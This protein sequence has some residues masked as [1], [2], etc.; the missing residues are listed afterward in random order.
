MNVSQV[1]TVKLL[2]VSDDPLLRQQISA[3]LSGSRQPA[4]EITLSTPAVFT[5]AE[6]ILD[7]FE[8]CL[9][10]TS[11]MRTPHSALIDQFLDRT[12]ALPVVMI[13]AESDLDSGWQALARGATGCVARQDLSEP[14]LKQSLCFALARHQS[15]IRWRRLA[16][17]D[18]L[19]Q[20]P[21]RA[22]FMEHLDNAIARAERLGD[23]LAVLFLDLDGF[24]AVNDQHGHA[25]GDELL[26]QVAERLRSTLRKGDITA[27]L[28]GDEFVVL[29]QPMNDPAQAEWLAQ[30]LLKAIQS[31]YRIGT[32]E[33]SIGVS[34]GIALYPEHGRDA[35][36]LLEIA[37]QAM[38]QVKARGK[39]DY[40]AGRAGRAGEARPA[41]RLDL[42]EAL[43]QGQLTLHFQPVVSSRDARV[44]ALE[45]LLRWQHPTRGLLSASQFLS[46]PGCDAVAGQL[47]RWVLN[48]GMQWRQRWVS[49]GWDMALALNLGS[50]E[51]STDYLVPALDDLVRR[52]GDLS[53][54]WL[55]VNISQL[56]PSDERAMEALLSA[57][58][59]GLTLALD[60][61]GGGAS[62]IETLT[63]LPA[64]VLKLDKAVVQRVSEQPL[65]KVLAQSTLDL[66]QRLALLPIA[67]GI[68]TPEQKRALEQLGFQLLQGNL[69]A[70]PLSGAELLHWLEQRHGT[71][72]NATMA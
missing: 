30:R 1:Q 12:D 58:E 67:S 31:P 33:V 50:Q 11:N 59:Y 47:V 63:R 45:G 9:L 20:L 70:P 54:L 65:Y 60:N 56:L 24:K 22:V 25:A 39:G 68:E 26:R 42:R 51:L 28:G 8:V 16:T 72:H 57:R 5:Q 27:R 4:F 35:P 37:D 62:C 15:E 36:S 44:V 53:G 46:S 69:L 48:E 3:L 71:V 17:H 6:F 21:R 38:Y 49:R 61:I 13:T 40:T 43:D 34:V 18:E 7:P 32:A 52:H 29:Q 41:P 19:T 55:E 64:G 66:C 2:V 14:V 10:D 23:K